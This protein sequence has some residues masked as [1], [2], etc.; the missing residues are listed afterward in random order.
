MFC[1]LFEKM[2]LHRFIETYCFNVK[3]AI[4]SNVIIIPYYYL[5]NLFNADST[6][7]YHT[8][9]QFYVSY[10]FFTKLMNFFNFQV[11]YQQ[12]QLMKNVHLMIL[13]FGKSLKRVNPGGNLLGEKEDLAGI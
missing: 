8:T 5:A 10:Y 9:S 12:V 3:E 13:L 7:Y 1:Y 4:V 11:T 6:N 2:F